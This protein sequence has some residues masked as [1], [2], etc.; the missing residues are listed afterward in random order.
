MVSRSPGSVD[1]FVR[2]VS[3]VLGRSWGKLVQPG[4]RSGAPITKGFMH[5]AHTQNAQRARRFLQ[6]LGLRAPSAPET[7]KLVESQIRDMAYNVRKLFQRTTAA[8]GEF[9]HR[10]VTG[11]PLSHARLTAKRWS[12]SRQNWELSFSSHVDGAARAVLA[13]SDAKY[14]V[15]MVPPRR[16]QNVAQGGT[17]GRH[18]F[19]V[20]T[21]TELDELFRELNGNRRPDSFSGWQTLGFHHGS[22][23]FYVPVP[24]T[25][26]LPLLYE[27]LQARRTAWMSSASS[28]G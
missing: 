22:F 15:V 9:L 16:L 2:K 5:R 19:R 14:F 25:V 24:D 12:M 23:E 26:D 13:A 8:V 20:M 27:H 10:V 4:K 3:N 28:H 21:R 7:K 17:T 11:M 18:L 6:K 1:R